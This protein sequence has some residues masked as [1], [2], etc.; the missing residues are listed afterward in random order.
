MLF[1]HW[2]RIFHHVVIPHEKAFFFSLHILTHN[3]DKLILYNQVELDLFSPQYT[4]SKL[5]RQAS[6][7]KNN[8][9]KYVS[10]YENSRKLRHAGNDL[11]T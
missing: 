9:N 10:H 7:K 2:I 3:T 11:Y 5:P 1:P 4:A 8:E 6:K